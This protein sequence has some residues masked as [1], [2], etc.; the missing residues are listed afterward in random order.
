MLKW[1]H[2]DGVQAGGQKEISCM[3]HIMTLRLIWFLFAK[4]ENAMCGVH[5]LVK[6]YDCVPRRSFISVLKRWVM[7]YNAGQH[8]FHVC[9]LQ[10]YSG[11]GSHSQRRW[12]KTGYTILATVVG[13]KQD[14]PSSC[15]SLIYI[16]FGIYMMS[17]RWF[18]QWLYCLLLIKD[19]V[20]VATSRDHCINELLLLLCCKESGM[21][22]NKIHGFKWNENKRPLS[23]PYPESQEAGSILHTFSYVYFR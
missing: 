9:N 21:T 1:Y 2:P 23:I 16:S 13:V 3:G 8:C 11:T 17:R 10:K 7:I 4:D 14:A 22:Q 18:W 19:I 15:F 6:A 12:S 5:R 20:I